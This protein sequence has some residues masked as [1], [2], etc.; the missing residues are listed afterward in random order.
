M[1]EPTQFLRRNAI[2]NFE[3]STWVSI[4]MNEKK[5]EWFS[6][7]SIVTSEKLMGVNSILTVKG[8][9]NVWVEVRP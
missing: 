8:L 4:K 3:Y 9:E 7:K 1:R 6:N 2:F 5:I